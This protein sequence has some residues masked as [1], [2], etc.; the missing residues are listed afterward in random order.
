MVRTYAMI[1][2]SKIKLFLFRVISCRK[3]SSAASPPSFLSLCYLLSTHLHTLSLQCLPSS[4]PPYLH[5]HS[6]PISLHPPSPCPLSLH[7]VLLRSPLPSTLPCSCLIKAPP[8][9]VGQI[10]GSTTDM[11]RTAQ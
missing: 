3:F 6:H 8:R 10:L 5:S 2:T 4:P 9:G 7:P 1:Y 11:N